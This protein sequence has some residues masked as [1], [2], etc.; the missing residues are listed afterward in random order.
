M[1]FAARRHFALLTASVALLSGVGAAATMSFATGILAR[2]HGHLA[3]ALFGLSI[4]SIVVSLLPLFLTSRRHAKAADIAAALCAA[5]RRESPH[6]FAK[7]RERNC[8]R[9]LT[10]P[11]STFELVI[12]FEAV[13]SE[14]GDR[15]MRRKLASKSVRFEQ[16]KVISCLGESC[17][18]SGHDP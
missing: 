17:Q 11:I 4:A 6:L 7:L 18:S 15:A 5:T 8:S 9:I 14:H 13:R 3:I 16:D 10:E 2:E 12:L 1:R